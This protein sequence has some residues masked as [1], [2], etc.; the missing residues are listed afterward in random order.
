MMKYH[1]RRES[2]SGFPAC[3]QNTR[4]QNVMGVALSPKLF[5]RLGDWERC[6]HCEKK[7]LFYRNIQR[8]IKGLPPVTQPFTEELR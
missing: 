6:S 3:N 5:K 1:L 8:T 2:G 4:R 7:F